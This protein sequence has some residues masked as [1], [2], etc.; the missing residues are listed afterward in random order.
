MFP[1]MVQSSGHMNSTIT[2]MSGCTIA[3]KHVSIYNVDE[4]K[5]LLH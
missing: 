4:E 1:S 2:V 3:V 5:S